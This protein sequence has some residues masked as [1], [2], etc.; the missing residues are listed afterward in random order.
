MSLTTEYAASDEVQDLLR[1]TYTTAESIPS[2]AMLKARL[3]A[4]FDLVVPDEA[5]E[6]DILF[7]I[8]DEAFTLADIQR[9]EAT[10][11]LELLREAAFTRSSKFRRAL[12]GKGGKK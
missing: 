11:L 9:D 4:Q 8:M 2:V 1:N 7:N 12:D 3:A 10:M 6:G 5:T